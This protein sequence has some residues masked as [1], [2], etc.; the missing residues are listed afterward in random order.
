MILDRRVPDQER[1]CSGLLAQLPARMLYR[2][3]EQPA[4]ALLKGDLN[5]HAPSR[6][7]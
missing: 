2:W 7:R 3:H 6:S 4:I 1:Q 5:L